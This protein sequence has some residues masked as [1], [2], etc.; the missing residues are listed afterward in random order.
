M[1]DAGN[2]ET[3]TETSGEPGIHLAGLDLRE[4]LDEIDDA[5]QAR[6][7]DR[8]LFVRDGQAREA[9]DL[10]DVLTGQAHRVG[11]Q[12]AQQLTQLKRRG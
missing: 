4:L 6:H 2:I 1:P 11:A 8:H 9:R 12:N 7:V 3:P 5:G 10:F